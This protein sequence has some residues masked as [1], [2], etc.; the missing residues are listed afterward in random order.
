MF[1]ERTRIALRPYVPTPVLLA[2]RRVQE[3]KRELPLARL[4]YI[5]RGKISFADRG[6]LVHRLRRAS[7]GIACMHT[8][9]EMA[10][11]IATILA[12]PPSVTGCIVEAGCYRGGSTAKLSLAAK[13][14]NRR[15]Y[16]FDS[17]AGLPANSE[18]HEQSMF[19]ERIDFLQGRYA[20]RLEE[21]RANVRQYGVE[22]IC[23]F[24]PG[25]F[26]ET[27]PHFHEPIAAA[28]I[29]V[30]LAASTRTCLEYL[31]PLLAPGGSLFSHDGHLP[32]CQEVFRDDAFW[33]DVVGHSR[34]PIPGF[35]QRK[36]LRI[37]KPLA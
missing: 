9:A 7:A 16:V 29:D 34:P 27:M 4:K 21:V 10:Q 22:E 33:R 24:V 14:V 8:H 19:G 6:A 11:V 32:L 5:P 1:S 35:G 31:Y 28:F 26:E 17:F 18:P 3:L 36:L 25:W 12:I 20:A 15:L 37:I 13:L 2:K 23:E 30:D